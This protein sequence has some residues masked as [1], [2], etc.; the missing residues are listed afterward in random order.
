MRMSSNRLHG[1]YQVIIAYTPLV[2][3]QDSNT[4]A[5]LTIF[6]GDG[7]IKISKEDD[8]GVGL[9]VGKRDRTHGGVIWNIMV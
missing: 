1:S 4:K 9:D 7:A 2:G 3:F 6:S 5:K 8:L